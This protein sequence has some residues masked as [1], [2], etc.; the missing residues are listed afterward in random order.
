MIQPIAWNSE[1]MTVGSG[2]GKSERG[3]VGLTS[4]ATGPRF[5]AKKALQ[6]AMVTGAP[7]NS[8]TIKRLPLFAVGPY[9]KGTLLPIAEGFSG[10][11]VPSTYD[12]NESRL[13]LLEIR[14]ASS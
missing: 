6:S 10:M 2:E 8:L 12:W 11:T 14:V 3:K 5:W 13:R 7:S 9:I 4:E 1:E